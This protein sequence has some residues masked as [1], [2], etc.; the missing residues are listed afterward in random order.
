MSSIQNAKAG[1][2]YQTATQ[3]PSCRNCYH[4]KE[5]RE[6]RMPPFDTARWRCKKAGFITSA[7][8]TCGEHQPVNRTP[9]HAAT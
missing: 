5:E 4:G 1:M 7:L 9:P 3:R 8:A 2:F 6:D